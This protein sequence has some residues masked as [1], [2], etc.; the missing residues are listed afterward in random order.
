MTNYT[1][2]TDNDL[3]AGALYDKVNDMADALNADKLERTAAGVRKANTAYISGNLVICE[4]HPEL[5]LKCTTAGTT[6]VGALDTSGSLSLGST[7][8][9]GSV[10][11]TAVS[12]NSIASGTDVNLTSLADGDLLK[13]DN[14][15]GKW[16]NTKNL[17]NVAFAST[18]STGT[19]TIKTTSTLGTTPSSDEDKNYGFIDSNGTWL[20]GFE[21]V[22]ATNGYNYKQITIRKQD[23]SNNFAIFA[24]GYNS[25]QQEYVDATPGI[26]AG[27]NSWGMPNYLSLSSVGFDGNNQ[28][29]APSNGYIAIYTESS[30]WYFQGYLGNLYINTGGNFSNYHEADT[31]LFPVAKGTILTRTAAHANVYFIPCLGG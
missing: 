13:Y 22:I 26:K 15:T 18:L 31:T 25:S 8:T 2:I 14:T 11:W 20:G 10:V 17:G 12:V 28:Y 16:I 27:I 30:G 19:Y 5:M 29:T 21:H 24:L 7:I 9:D 3:A 23:G 1:K 4:Y 6:A